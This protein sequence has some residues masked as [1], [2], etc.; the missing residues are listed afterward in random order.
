M[1]ALVFLTRVFMAANPLI[2]LLVWTA[3]TFALDNLTRASMAVQSH[4]LSPTARL[5]NRIST[6]PGHG[7]KSAGYSYSQNHTR[8]R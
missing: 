6:D 1:F 5:E 2:L 4:V 8:H 7:T 3:F